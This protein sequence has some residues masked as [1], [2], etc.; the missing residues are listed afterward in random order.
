[1]DE[2]IYKLTSKELEFAE[3]CLKRKLYDFEKLLLAKALFEVKNIKPE[4]YE[5]NY[6]NSEDYLKRRY[7]YNE[8]Y[9]GIVILQQDKESE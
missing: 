1:M 2:K 8:P 6:F 3:K 9:K 5:F 7:F 4:R